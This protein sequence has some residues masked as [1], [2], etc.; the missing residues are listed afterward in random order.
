MQTLTRTHAHTHTRTH[1]NAHTNTPISTSFFLVLY[2]V[3]DSNK[4]DIYWHIIFSF[5]EGLK[6]ISFDGSN[7]VQNF[8]NLIWFS[9]TRLS[10]SLIKTWKQP[11]E[12]KHCSAHPGLRNT[13]MT[14]ILY[15]EFSFSIHSYFCCFCGFI[16]HQIF[17]PGSHSYCNL[18]SWPGLLAF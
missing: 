6:V 12:K 2:Q 7:N 1:A 10:L 9:L 14:E 11:T 17:T 5:L 8:G 13:C 4:T 18:C 16:W 15:W 3:Y